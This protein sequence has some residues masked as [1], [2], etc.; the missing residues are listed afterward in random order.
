LTEL[1]EVDGARTISI[2]NDQSAYHFFTKNDIFQQ[3]QAVEQAMGVFTLG[4]RYSS[5]VFHGIMIA[6]FSIDTKSA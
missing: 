6:A 1:G 3:R 4:N 5:D 2:L